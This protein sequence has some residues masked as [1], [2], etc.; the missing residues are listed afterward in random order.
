MPATMIQQH[1]DTNIFIENCIMLL[2]IQ[3]KTNNIRCLLAKNQ[4]KTCM[5][6][7][8]TIIKNVKHN[9]II[10][11]SQLTSLGDAIALK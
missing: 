2:V 4:K 7:W 11:Q 10:D 6:Q 9:A 5:M 3:G 8:N 1:K